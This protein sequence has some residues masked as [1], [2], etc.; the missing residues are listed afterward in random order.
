MK[1]VNM[2]SVFT[3][4]RFFKIIVNPKKQVSVLVFKL[5]HFLLSKIKLTA[6]TVGETLIKQ[7]ITIEADKEN[8]RF[9][10]CRSR[11]KWEIINSL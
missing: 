7:I 9:A 8:N 4:S 5:T 2:S 6:L 10:K 11:A 3:L 1:S